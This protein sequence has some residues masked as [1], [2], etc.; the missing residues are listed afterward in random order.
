MRYAVNSLPTLLAFDRGEPQ[1]ETRVTR[2]EDLKREAFLREWIETEAKR[3][4][5]GGAGGGTG[6]G[7]F[8]AIF[9]R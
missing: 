2:V 9:G 6:R 7:L 5:D 1:L 4:G 3:H 8:G